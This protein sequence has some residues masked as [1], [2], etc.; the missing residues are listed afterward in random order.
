[1][2]STLQ[3]SVSC[4][5][6]VYHL[7]LAAFQGPFPALQ[8]GQHSRCS[9]HP[10]QLSWALREQLTVNQDSVVLCCLLMGNTQALTG[11]PLKCSQSHRDQFDLQA[12]KKR[13]L[14]F[15]C[16]MAWPQHS[17]SDGEK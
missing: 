3:P 1:M 8:V 6:E 10:G 16:T 13:Q 2:S 11:S 5:P 17:L 15:F 12:L 4:D 7:G 9:V 14:I